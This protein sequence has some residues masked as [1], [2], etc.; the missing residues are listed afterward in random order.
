MSCH[1]LL[2]WGKFSIPHQ[3]W[4]PNN[5]YKQETRRSHVREITVGGVG[6]RRD[7]EIK[8]RRQNVQLYG[9][10]CYSEAPTQAYSRTHRALSIRLSAFSAYVYHAGTA[11]SYTVS[12]RSIC[13]ESVWRRAVGECLPICRSGFNSWRTSFFYFLQLAKN[14]Y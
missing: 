10:C 9:P 8:N 3:F 4:R 6:V 12:I 13:K 5:A 11:A 7:G 2:F 14:F 1:T